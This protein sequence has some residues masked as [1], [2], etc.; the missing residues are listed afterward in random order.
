MKI[1]LCNG[2][3]PPFAGGGGVYTALLARGLAKHS[4]DTQVIVY[5]GSPDPA[6]D[7]RLDRLGPN[8]VIYY[9]KKLWELDYG[10]S[11]FLDVVQDF[12][13]V[14]KLFK[15]D[16]IHV[17]HTMEC[18]LVGMVAD[19]HKIPFI[20][21]I[22]KSPV[23]DIEDLKKPSWTAVRFAYLHLPY[24]GVVATS[25]AYE[26]QAIITGSIKYFTLRHSG[27]VLLENSASPPS[28]GLGWIGGRRAHCRSTPS[29]P[30]A[31]FAPRRWS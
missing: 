27:H 6:Y 3:Y 17:H 23:P 15:P 10:G 9:S 25:K 14:I 8:Q 12:E 29:D 30:G 2:E 1:L 16:L 28:D 21:T 4:T 19:K 26:E 5:A 18:L 24:A 22:Q 7:K 31:W 13:E 11:S 20:I